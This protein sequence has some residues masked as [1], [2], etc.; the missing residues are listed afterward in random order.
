[1][2]FP[3]GF[4]NAQLA[5]LLFVNS[6]FGCAKKKR[7]WNTNE[8]LINTLIKS[9]FFCSPLSTYTAWVPRPNLLSLCILVGLCRWH[10]RSLH[11]TRV[12]RLLRPVWQCDIHEAVWSEQERHQWLVAA[13]R[14][15]RTYQRHPSNTLWNHFDIWHSQLWKMDEH[16]PFIEI[17]L[18][19]C[20]LYL[21]EIMISRTILLYK[22]PP[23]LWHFSMFLISSPRWPIFKRRRNI[24]RRTTTRRISKTKKTKQKET[25]RKTQPGLVGE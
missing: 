19:I 10:S 24:R 4:T 2:G 12:P 18:P 22:L 11:W 17:Y 8:Y 3:A 7:N 16:G 13:R 20:L 14:C 23:W 15:G 25:K 6:L 21:F 9:H 1:M 5:S